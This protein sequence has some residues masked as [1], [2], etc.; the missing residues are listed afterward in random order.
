MRVLVAED[1]EVLA[2]SIAG[3]LRRDGIPVRHTLAASVRL[4][5]EVS[6]HDTPHTPVPLVDDARAK[7]RGLDQLQGDILGNRGQK[8]RAATHHDRIAEH[9]QLVDEAE[10]DGRC[11]DRGGG[12]DARC[13]TR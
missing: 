11:Q 3:R 1:F 5:S 9:T 13:G 12:A 6:I 4:P 8:R 7:R 2:R 10:L